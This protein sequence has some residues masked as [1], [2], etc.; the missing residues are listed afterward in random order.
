QDFS[1][2]PFPDYSIFERDGRLDWLSPHA[3]ESEE[4][5]TLPVLSG[6][7][8]PYR[9][10]YCSNTS[11]L[12]LFKGQGTFLRKHDP[13]ELTEEFVRLREV[14]DIEYFQFW[15]E[16]FT[17][18]RKYAYELMSLYGQHV[19]IPFSIFARVEQMNDE[20]CR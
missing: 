3:V 12:E 11:L 16:L 5:N 9:C 18:D 1:N 17:F 7:G 10:S 14:Y 2:L 4:L 13:S 20:F 15:D 8:C 6:R 19:K